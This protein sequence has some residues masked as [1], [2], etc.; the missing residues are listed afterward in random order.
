MSLLCASRAAG[1]AQQVRACPLR[2][3]R[4]TIGV[5]A[6]LFA[7]SARSARA[8]TSAT[9]A[10]AGLRTL[11]FAGQ[12]W[13]VRSGDGNPGNGCWSDSPQSVWVD[14]A[15]QLHLVMRQVNGRWCQAE[16]FALDP[17]REGRHRWR[18]QSLHAL[19]R[20]AVLGMFLYREHP[21]VGGSCATDLCPYHPDANACIC[22][23]DI[24]LTAAFEGTTCAGGAIPPGTRATYTVQPGAT[25]QSC[26][27]MPVDPTVA[28][29]YGFNWRDPRSATVSFASWKGDCS[30]GPCDGAIGAWT[31]SGA[32]DF[33]D[34]AEPVSVINLW[35]CAWGGVCNGTV[36]AEQEVVVS[37]YRS[38]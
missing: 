36:A 7:L 26:A 37:T 4:I 32:N 19:D 10:P 38:R 18:V 30:R 20:N 2:S 5:I 21:T 34:A 33:S 28:S 24:E 9:L 17:A 13:G 15:G 23:I 1:A 25:A 6:L 16:V 35:A 31:Y 11:V 27:S 14:A 3:W 8:S 29:S 12:T 22:E